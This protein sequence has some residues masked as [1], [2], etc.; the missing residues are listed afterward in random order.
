MLKYRYMEYFKPYHF[1]NASHIF[2]MGWGLCLN[3]L[4]KFHKLLIN[5]ILFVFSSRWEKY[6]ASYFESFACLMMPR[7]TIHLNYFLK[8]ALCVAPPSESRIPDPA[9]TLSDP[10]N[11]CLSVIRR[12]PGIRFCLYI[13]TGSHVLV[14]CK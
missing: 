12:P 3:W 5:F 13:C 14:N 4:L 6:G 2:G 9:V 7:L 11:D 8:I 1:N 10:D